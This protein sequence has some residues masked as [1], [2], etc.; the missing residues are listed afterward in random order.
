[1]NINEK[2]ELYAKGKFSETMDQLIA[3]AY[4]DGYS[5]GYCAASAGAAEISKLMDGD[6]EYVDL[7]L[8]SG[9]LWSS[10]YLKNGDEIQYLPYV[11]TEGMSLPTEEM[12]DELLNRCRFVKETD[13]SGFL[14]C[15][16]C[17]GLNGN[18]ITFNVTGMKE[19]DSLSKRA[20]VCF[21]I[22]EEVKDD[23]CLHAEM[24]HSSSE[25]YKWKYSAYVGYRLPVRTVK[26]V[27]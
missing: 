27:R 16:K 22:D 14:C 24:W 19:V 7:G 9:T 2:S 3:Q 13:S 5:D 6:T 25:L 11:K 20:S 12:Y 15:V 17:I 18:Y 10:D 21:W 23:K 4:S 1:M 8:P 26:T